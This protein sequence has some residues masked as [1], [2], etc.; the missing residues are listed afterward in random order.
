MII[1]SSVRFLSKK[2]NQTEFFLKKPNPVQTDRF[3]SGSVI[4]GQKPVQTGL[5]RFFCFSLIFSVWLGFDSVFLVWLCW[6]GF[7]PVCLV[8]SGL[9]SI[10]FGFLLIKSN[11]TGL[12]FQNFNQFD[13]FFFQ[14]LFFR[15]FFFRVFLVILLTPNLNHEFDR[16]SWVCST[17]ITEITSLLC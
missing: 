2:S 6:L 1:F 3:R 16:I 8:F 5:A 15:L 13:R 7:F 17:L 10:R 14:F 4:L 12:F 9:G 11:R